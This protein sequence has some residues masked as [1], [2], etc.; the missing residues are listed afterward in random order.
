MA[1]QNSFTKKRVTLLVVICGLCIL[2]ILIPLFSLD[3]SSHRFEIIGGIFSCLLFVYAIY[4][5]IQKYKQ[6][7][8]D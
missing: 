4:V 7:K 1:D 5:F 3:W 8:T 6:S 2:L